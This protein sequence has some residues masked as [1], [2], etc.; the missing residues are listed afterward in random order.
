MGIAALRLV[1]SGFLS[2]HATKRKTTENGALTNYYVASGN[3]LFFH[4][5]LLFRC[6]AICVT[7]ILF[8]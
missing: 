4:K 7:K 3:L 6:S 2:F 1:G 8:A 5:S